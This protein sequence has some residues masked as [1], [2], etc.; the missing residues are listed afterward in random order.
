M[1]GPRLETL[2]KRPDFLYAASQG[3]KYVSPALVVQAVKQRGACDQSPVRVG[4]TATKKL[5]NAVVRNRIKRR[6]RAVAD[7]IL[8]H[9]ARP[10]VDYV[11]IGRKICVQY[12]YDA[13]CRD[14]EKAVIYLNKK[15]T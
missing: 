13:L 11:L 2:K 14:L 12:P 10:G 7:E 5:G 8:V 6:M 4:F 15:I 3:I 9:H 1:T